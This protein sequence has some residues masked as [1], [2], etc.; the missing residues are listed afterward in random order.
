MSENED[1]RKAKP[2]DIFDKLFSTSMNYHPITTDQN[3][4]MT[5]SSRVNNNIKINNNDK[6]KNSTSENIQIEEIAEE[7]QQNLRS[8]NP[9]TPLNEN[10]REKWMKND[11]MLEYMMKAEEAPAYRNY[12]RLNGSVKPSWFPGYALISPFIPDCIRITSDP[13]EP[14][15]E[16]WR[17]LSTSTL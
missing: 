6:R 14:L 12:V 5:R 16:A 11:D 1:L 7:N 2:D 17:L 10:T 3:E 9:L 15:L 4:T 13:D 8:K